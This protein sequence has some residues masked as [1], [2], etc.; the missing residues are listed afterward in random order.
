MIGSVP[1]GLTIIQFCV[2]KVILMPSVVSED[3]FSSFSL[4]IIFCASSLEH[5]ILVFV[6]K[7]GGKRSTIFDMVLPVLASKSS[8]NAKVI[9]PSLTGLCFPYINPPFSSNPMIAFIG[10]IFLDTSTLP[11]FVRTTVAFDLSAIFSILEPEL[12]QVTT[13]D[14]GFFSKMYF[15]NKRADLSPVKIVPLLS[16]K[17]LRSPSPSNAI[18]KSDS[19]F[20]TVSESSER[21]SGVGSEPRPGNVPSILSLIKIT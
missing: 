4:V 20:F 13:V 10:T 14:L 7:E 3:G 1:L 6:V 12:R 5:E 8:A 11:I 16:Q 2:L 21:F 17:R 19:V 9:P 15:D 18:P